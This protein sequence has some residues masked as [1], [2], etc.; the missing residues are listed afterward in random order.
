M[1]KARKTT[2]EKSFLQ[3]IGETVTHVKDALVEAKDDV[4]EGLQEKVT[5]IKKNIQQ[6]KEAAHQ[7]NFC[8]EKHCQE[9]S[10]K[11]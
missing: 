2:K 11:D 4:V 8:E 7:E 3:R 9:T 5:E 1:A 6:K 10:F